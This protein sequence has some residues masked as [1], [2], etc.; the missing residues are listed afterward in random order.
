MDDI[1][2]EFLTETSDSM[3]ELDNLL[4]LLEQSPQDMDLITKIF[5]IIHTIKGTCGFL[6]LPRLEKIAHKSEDLL[7][8]FRD[9]KLVADPAGISA[10]LAA[11]DRIKQIIPGLKP[12]GM[13]LKVMIPMSQASWKLWQ[14]GIWARRYQMIWQ[15][16][17]WH[18]LPWRFP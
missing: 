13:N 15:S 11:L 16:M 7:G 17:T 4:V 3:T 2:A 1:I 6:G 5:R 18:R 8:L 10:I 14:M 9:R 12:P